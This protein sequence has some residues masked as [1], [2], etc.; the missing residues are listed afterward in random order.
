MA[1]RKIPRSDRDCTDMGRP[2]STTEGGIRR[3]AEEQG[4]PQR[5]LGRVIGHHRAGKDGMV[6]EGTTRDVRRL[7]E[8]VTGP[9][10]K[11]PRN[12]DLIARAAE[13]LQEMGFSDFER[14]RILINIPRP[15]SIKPITTKSANPVFSVISEDGR[16]LFV[17]KMPLR[18]GYNVEK[19]VLEVLSELEGE[20]RY[21]KR[22]FPDIA[23]ET[24]DFDNFL[25]LITELP[26][27]P[28]LD[29]REVTR[30]RMR[31]LGRLHGLSPA[32]QR[33]LE[34]KGLG[35]LLPDGKNYGDPS[36]LMG[37]INTHLK[38]KYRFS[39]REVAR[40]V[41]LYN[42]SA[43]SLRDAT[44][45]SRHR[46]IVSPDTKDENWDST[47]HLDFEK[48]RWGAR[49]ESFSRVLF[50]KFAYDNSN[51]PDYLES[52]LEL[53]LFEETDTVEADRWMPHTGPAFI[54]E[55]SDLTLNAAFIDM[56]RL[57]HYN[58]TTN[59]TDAKEHNKVYYA[60]FR[61]LL[62]YYG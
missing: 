28:V 23:P 15:L 45:D 35:N 29:P 39:P 6:P 33:E 48:V 61:M 56:L 36:R 43:R 19:E 47:I 25:Y 52:F 40:I 38:Q 10:P 41:S 50:D 37:E 62:N 4:W 27:I 60:N 18:E 16:Y 53:S 54:E 24:F 5:V 26:D 57:L 8:P 14:G 31:V 7:A 42:S 55:T 21:N 32:I 1:K 58:I 11:V 3:R 46:R 12:Y 22:F 59:K 2:E 9:D 34:R 20:G 49:P 51:V 17:K 30:E 13:A 44:R